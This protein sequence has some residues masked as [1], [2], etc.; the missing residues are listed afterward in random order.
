MWR[1]L[2]ARLGLYDPHRGPRFVIHQKYRVDLPFPQY[3]ARRPFRVLSYLE[4]RH[5]LERGMLRRPRP[6]SLKRLQLVHDPAYLA[7]LEEPNALEPILG[8]RLDSRQQDDFLAF[9]RLVCGGTV[10]ALRYAYYHRAIGVNLGGGFHHATRTSGSGFCAFNDVAVAIAM[11]RE[12]GLDERVLVVDLDL[13]DGDGTRAVFADDPSVHTYSL[14]NTDLGGPQ[15][16]EATSVAL[17]ADVDDATLLQTLQETLPP[18]VDRFAPDLAIYL[19]GSDPSVDDGLGNWRL[20]LAGMLQRDRFVMATLA[21]AK[22]SS[23]PVRRQPPGDVPGRTV[24]IPCAILL[25]GGYGRRSWRH[26][27]AFFSWLLTGNSRLDVPLELELPVDNYRRLARLMRHPGLRH[28]ERA[29]GRGGSSRAE[30]DRDDWGLSE[31]ELDGLGRPAANDLFLGLFT[32][33]G[34]ELALERAGL[35]DRL[36][37]LGFRGA[38]LLIDPPDPLGHTMRIVTNDEQALVLLEIRLRVDRTVEPGRSYLAV[39]WLLLQDTRS[40]LQL[41]RP[42]LPGQKYPGLGLLRD[43]AAVLVV[44]CERLGLDGLTFTPSHYHLSALS[45]PMAF[46]ADPAAEGRF[47]AVSHAVAHLR[48][49]EASAAVEAGGVV[50]MRTGRPYRWRPA[51]LVIPV[52]EDLRQY[53]LSY[54]YTA[55]V[56]AV[57]GAHDYRLR[58]GAP[59]EGRSE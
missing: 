54:A 49:Q 46:A 56:A 53:F 17:G 7:S 19:A 51:R 58:D 28:D 37:Q 12:R 48:L 9:Q 59:D 33:Y 20:T 13:H 44:L 32:R 6:V 16:V 47:Q 14:H 30:D 8:L 41:D 29:P 36:R 25:A 2:I 57:R 15:A 11:L 40:R 18:V 24:G 23:T 27:A 55:A 1:R 31:D 35:L 5:L 42:L 39:E 22:P 26:A 52:G 10:H 45:R 34:L 21:D 50:D 4:M 3:D 43:T 38:R